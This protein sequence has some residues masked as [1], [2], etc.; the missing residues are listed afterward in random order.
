[1]LYSRDHVWIDESDPS[2]ARVGITRFFG[3]PGDPVAVRA[4]VDFS[5]I[6][7]RA[8]IPLRDLNGDPEGAGY[9]ATV[10][11]SDTTQFAGLMDP[12]EYRDYCENIDDVWN[13]TNNPARCPP[14]PYETGDT[15]AT[16]EG[17]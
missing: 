14:D 5:I 7:F 4:P 3:G 13:A 12:G 11:C 2:R 8:N 17:A 10:N 6:D 16:I 9:I 15:F 1:M